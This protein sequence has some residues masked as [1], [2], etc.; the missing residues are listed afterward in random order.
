MFQKAQQGRRW[1]WLRNGKFSK[2]LLCLQCS[3]R[4]AVDL[5]RGVEIERMDPKII[6][7]IQL[8]H[9]HRGG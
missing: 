6:K 3:T 9:E 8:T 2:C 1:G 5:G 7:C 4:Q